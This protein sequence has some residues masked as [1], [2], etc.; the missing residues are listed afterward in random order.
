M[1]AD[2]WSIVS[3]A[4]VRLSTS[5]VGVVSLNGTAPIL[6]GTL[7]QASGDTTLD[8]EIALDQVKTNVFLQSAIRSFVKKYEATRLTYHGE[9]ESGAS[10]V[11]VSGVAHA[12]T[13]EIQLDLSIESDS[14]TA[15]LTGTA[16][17]GTVDIPLPGLGRVENFSFDVDAQVNLRRS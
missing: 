1:S 10:P 5:R 16:R 14:D 2:S 11:V 13:I 3:G 6:S 4:L 12:G 17:L 8:L 15:H 7:V 9:G